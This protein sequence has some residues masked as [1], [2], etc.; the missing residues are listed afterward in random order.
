M[1]DII[2][3]H[4]IKYFECLNTNDKDICNKMY[5]NIPLKADT[6]GAIQQPIKQK[7]QGREQVYKQTWKFVNRGNF[8]KK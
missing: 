2:E 4:Y 1:N 3:E 7:K 6:C 8:I 5:L